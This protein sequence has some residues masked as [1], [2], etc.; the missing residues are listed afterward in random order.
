SSVNTKTA[1][2]VFPAMTIP[3]KRCM[4]ITAIVAYSV[5]LLVELTT[6]RPKRIMSQVQKQMTEA[7][8]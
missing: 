5:T 1:R 7:L 4:R 8:V 2:F 3:V 6:S